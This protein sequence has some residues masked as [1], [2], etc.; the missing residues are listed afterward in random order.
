MNTIRST[1]RKCEHVYLTTFLTFTFGAPYHPAPL[2]KSNLLLRPSKK[3][4]KPNTNTL[5]EL[6]I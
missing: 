1:I 6:C 3:P 5:S 2:P 4:F